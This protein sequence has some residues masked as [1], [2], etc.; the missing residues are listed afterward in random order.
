[1]KKPNEED[2]IQVKKT[3]GSSNHKY[4]RLRID[5]AIKEGRLTDVQ[6]DYMKKILALYDE[7]KIINEISK[8][9]KDAV[10]K[11]LDSVKVYQI[12]KNNIPETYLTNK[13]E[14]KK[15]E[16]IHTEIILSEFLI[17]DNNG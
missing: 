12:I 13:T 9:I 11:E 5:F 14:V 6:E 2:D 1:M 7:G 8:S 15:D 17:G 4:V 16:N 3:G 10:E